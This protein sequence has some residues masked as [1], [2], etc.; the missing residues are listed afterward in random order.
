VIEPGQ[1]QVFDVVLMREM[2]VIRHVGVVV[3]PGLLLHVQREGTSLIERYGHG[4]LKHRV[5]GFYR[6]RDQ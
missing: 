6:F 2:G 4:P 3:Q 1:E 5:A